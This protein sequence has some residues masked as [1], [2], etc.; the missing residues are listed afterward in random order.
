MVT[1][2][3]GKRAYIKLLNLEKR[4]EKL[5]K[6]SSEV[7]YSQLN[8][9]LSGADISTNFNKSFKL[10]V[11]KEGVYTFNCSMQS[12]LDSLINVRVEILV[13]SVVVC[14]QD[15]YYSK[16]NTF[17]FEAPLREGVNEITCKI[18]S[19]NP[20]SLTELSFRVNGFINYVKT[21]N[22]LSHV[23][24]GGAD[25]ILH[26][27]D[28]GAT[29]YSYSQSELKKAVTLNELSECSIIGAKSG[30]LY[31]LG[32]TTE[33]N[34]VVYRVNLERCTTSSL[35]LN[36]TGASSACGYSINDVFT[37]I[38]AKDGEIFKGKYVFGLPFSYER[39]NLKGVKLVTCPSA[40]GA[41]IVV[42]K[43]L[44]AKLVI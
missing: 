39:I 12:S 1:E 15:N 42:D 29:L 10:E 20:M 35:M 16:K 33:K 8:F 26:L 14:N 21:T 17:S 32:L 25:Y 2:D 24:Y 38:F 13:N 41:F 19:S 28:K 7:S 23:S 11:G 34:L 37:I 43:Y 5:E 22:A 4:L 18:S 6:E 30:Y 27:K 40:N 3:Y 31:I 44:N 9:D 36:I